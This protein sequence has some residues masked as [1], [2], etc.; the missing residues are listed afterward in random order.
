M[1]YF[2]TSK[3]GNILGSKRPQLYS[4]P[5]ESCIRCPLDSV[6]KTFFTCPNGVKYLSLSR[7]KIW[8]INV[9]LNINYP[10]SSFTLV[11]TDF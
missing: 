6:T 3:M 7:R 4:F 5:F 10:F 11:K 8:K 2:F 1:E 9:I